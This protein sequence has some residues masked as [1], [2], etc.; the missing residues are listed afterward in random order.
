MGTSLVVGDK[1]GMEIVGSTIAA[2]AYQ[3]GAWTQLGT[4]SDGAYTAAGKIGVR[5]SDSGANSRIDD[6]GGGTVAGGQTPPYVNV[7]IA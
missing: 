4:R 2:Y 1:V 3:S 6:F 5:L 7:S